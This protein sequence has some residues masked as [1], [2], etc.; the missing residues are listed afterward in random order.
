MD[1][2]PPGFSVHGISQAGILGTS[3]VVLVVKN[4]SADA[5]G[6]RDVGSVSGSGRSP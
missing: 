3:Q 2:S 1:C 6:I 5:G 4:Q